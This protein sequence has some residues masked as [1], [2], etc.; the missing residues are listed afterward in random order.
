MLASSCALTE[1]ACQ[2]IHGCFLSLSSAGPFLIACNNDKIFLSVNARKGDIIEGTEDVHQ[3]SEFFVIHDD[4]NH[5]YE[6]RIA[7]F[8]CSTY[9]NRPRRSSSFL[10][11]TSNPDV[12]PVAQYLS[13]P[14]NV[15]GQ[16]H[17]PLRVQHQVTATDARLMLCSRL[18]RGHCP[19]QATSWVQGR[20]IFYIGCARRGR[21][22]TKSY[23]CVQL[24]QQVHSASYMYTTTCISSPSSHN[25][26]NKFMLFRL[27]PPNVTQDAEENVPALP[28][29]KDLNDGLMRRSIKQSIAAQSADVCPKDT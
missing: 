18:R 29:L 12:L 15:L 7:F 14:V 6:F 1:C 8:R 26:E 22:H 20:E 27:L 21:L 25:R 13:A 11:I 24:K 3:A 17:G 23:I 5:P 2:I 4:G 9:R 28:S 16:N 19:A 10:N